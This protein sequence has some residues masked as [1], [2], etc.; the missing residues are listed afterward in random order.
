MST[1]S[2]IVLAGFVGVCFLAAMSGAVFRPDAWH[3]RLAKPW[4]APPRWLFA[5][6]WSVLYLTIAI[7]GWLVWRHAGFVA[8]AVPLSVYGISL[9]F[10]A[11]WSGLFFGLHRPDLAF[12]DILLLWLSIAATISV[13]APLDAGSAWLLVPY[14]CWVTFAGAL[15]YAIWRMNRTSGRLGAARS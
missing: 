10:N 6:A 12:L 3:A 13:F 11:A 7:A 4:W 5:P 1:H 9:L 2:A 8:A 14:L 15:N